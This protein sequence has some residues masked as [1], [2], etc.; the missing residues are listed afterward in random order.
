MDKEVKARLRWVKM[1]EITGNAGLTCRRCGI[2]RPTLRLWYRRWQEHGMDGLASRSRRPKNSPNQKRSNSLNARILSMRKKRNLGARRLQSEL[3]REDDLK[4]SL[5]TIHKVLSDADVKPLQTPPRGKHTKRYSRPIPGDRVQMDTR[6]IAKGIYQYTAVDD[7]T[8]C[9]VMRIYKRRTAKN[10]LGFIDAVIE[11]M[12][13]PIQRFQTDRGTEFFAYKV[14]ERLQDYGIKFRPN[15]PG[16]P[17]LNG[18]VERS[19]KTDK[20]EFYAL[21]DLDDPELSERLAEWQFYYNWQRPHGSLNGKT[22]MQ[23]AA[24]LADTTPLWEDVGR[25][26]G[27]ENERLQHQNYQVDLEVRKLKEC[28]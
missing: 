18:K 14:Q 6:K 27:P 4:L 2:S 9:R 22:P 28:P 15:R 25:Q 26:Y 1:Y 23:V 11:E 16:A 20:I 19:Q 21:A 13:F 8:R 24:K 3:F 5:A 12:D 17:Q 7:C 10:T